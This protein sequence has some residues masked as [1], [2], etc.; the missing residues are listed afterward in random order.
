MMVSQPHGKDM[1]HLISGNVGII[2]ANIGPVGVLSHFPHDGG[3]IHNP[4]IGGKVALRVLTDTHLI[5]STGFGV[6][7]KEVRPAQ[8]IRSGQ[9]IGSNDSIVVAIGLHLHGPQTIHGPVANL[10]HHSQVR[11]AGAS[12]TEG[13]VTH[14]IKVIVAVQH[15]GKRGARNHIHTA[16]EVDIVGGAGSVQITVQNIVG[17]PGVLLGRSGTGS[18]LT[19]D[20]AAHSQHAAVGSYHGV[21]KTVHIAGSTPYVD[22]IIGAADSDIHNLIQYPVLASAVQRSAHLIPPTVPFVGGKVMVLIQE[23][24]VHIVNCAIFHQDH[25]RMVAGRGSHRLLAS[26]HSPLSGIVIIT[27][28]PNRIATRRSSMPRDPGVS[29]AQKPNLA[30]SVYR[31]SKLLA[32][33]N[34]DNV[35]QRSTVTLQNLIGIGIVNGIFI[36][37]TLLHAAAACPTAGSTGFKISTGGQLAIVVITPSPQS[38]VSLQGQRIILATGDHGRR[39]SLLTLNG[40]SDLG[41]VP[42]SIIGGDGGTA[43]DTVLIGH[44]IQFTTLVLPSHHPLIAG[45]EASH[46]SNG[47]PHRI[48]GKLIGVK[49][50]VIIIVHAS[51]D[52]PSSKVTNRV[53]TSSPSSFRVSMV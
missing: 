44:Q 40:N 21:G 11:I 45:T 17:Y 31:Q 22:T 2:V 48:P 49:A 3:D 4:A 53:S 46:L 43:V 35:L 42:G 33:G 24:I 5:H 34:R 37:V 18:R 19:V 13:L 29:I 52:S 12:S 9:F 51:M 27:D 32:G 26:G 50:L 16:P 23:L 39:H 41:H 10:G 14:D 47:L 38:A 6:D 8:L 7:A 1:I 28:M 36:T 20:I 15:H 30:V 25:T